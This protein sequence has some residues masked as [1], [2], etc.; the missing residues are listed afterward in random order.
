MNQLKDLDCNKENI[1]YDTNVKEEFSKI[2]DQYL[3]NHHRFDHGSLADIL[4]YA[5]PYYDSKCEKPTDQEL[6]NMAENA[7][8]YYQKI[9]KNIQT[10]NFKTWLQFKENPIFQKIIKILKY[11]QQQLEERYGKTRANIIVKTT[12]TSGLIPIP[13][14][15]VITILTLLGISE[16]NRILNKQ[17]ILDDNA[18]DVNL[19]IKDLEKITYQSS[20]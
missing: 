15:Q 4:R 12:L 18:K 14:I 1:N 5:S 6:I 3:K 20:R 8:N 13:G 10:E 17:K 7:W 9:R 11:H 19:I 2:Y 16:I